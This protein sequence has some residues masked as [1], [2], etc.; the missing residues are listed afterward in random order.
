MLDS[1]KVEVKD[2]TPESLHQSDIEADE[3]DHNNE[4]MTAS[5]NY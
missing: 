4:A 1:F 3:P 5:K 2:D